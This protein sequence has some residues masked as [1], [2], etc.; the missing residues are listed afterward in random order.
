MSA[1]PPQLFPA[2]AALIPCP[3]MDRQSKRR[4]VRADSYLKRRPD[5][6]AA[7]ASLRG[8]ATSSRTVMGDGW[9]GEDGHELLAE[10]AAGDEPLVVLRGRNP[11]RCRSLGSVG[12]GR[13][14]AAGLPPRC[15]RKIYVGSRCPPPCRAA[16]GRLWESVWRAISRPGASAPSF[17]R[18]S[19]GR[20]SATPRRLPPIGTALAPGPLRCENGAS[21][22]A[23]D[24]RS[25][26]V[27]ETQEVEC[28]APF[29]NCA[30]SL[31][32]ATP[33]GRERLADARGD[34]NPRDAL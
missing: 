8:G 22:I 26:V 5:D 31:P 21:C 1:P 33:D 17:Q 9:V 18:G 4:R 23:A 15:A 13:F 20:G 6:R 27:A 25:Q 32:P 2:G 16:S 3:Q 30:D 10:V 19:A 24:E 34:L 28:K 14:G 29:V 12:A 7:Q 11:G